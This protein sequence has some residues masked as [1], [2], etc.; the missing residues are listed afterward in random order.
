MLMVYLDE[1]GH[2]TPEHVVVA[3]FIGAEEQWAAFETEWLSALKGPP[4]FHA[5]KLRWNQEATRRRVANLSAIPYRH[6]LRSVVGG[7][8]VSDYADL[9]KNMAEVYTNQGYLMALYPILS[10]VSAYIPETETVRWVLE[11]Q[12]DYE[13]PART[14]IEQFAVMYGAS[15]FSEVSFVSKKSTPRLHPADLLSFAVLHGMR[16]PS[17]KK[18]RW[19][20]PI[21]GDDPW[22]SVVERER[23]REIL[24]TGL[25]LT[26]AIKRQ[27]TGID[28]R[29]LFQKYQSKREIHEIIRDAKTRAGK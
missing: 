13:Q 15:R 24:G 17:S 6:E 4:T 19:S 2:E 1:S 7:V 26:N 14:V 11:E 28:H 20:A 5:T 8:R 9:L 27:E 16:D 21:L 3:G 29:Q 25:M 10:A 12:H 18:A 23:I 22:G